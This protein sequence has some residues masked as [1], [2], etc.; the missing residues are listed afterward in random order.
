MLHSH[1]SAITLARNSTTPQDEEEQL[2]VGNSEGARTVVSSDDF[3]QSQK[4]SK[5]NITKEEMSKYFN[6]PQVLAARLL[7]VSVSTLKRRYYEMFKGRWPYQSLS[8]TERKKSI[9]FYVNEE[10]HPEK[11]IPNE[12]LM[13]LQKAFSDCTKPSN[14]Y[15]ISTLQGQDP[16]KKEIQFLSYVPQQADGSN[17][18]GMSKE[19]SQSEKGMFVGGSRQRYKKQTGSPRK[20]RKKQ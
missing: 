7:N 11:L 20:L 9:W 3:N 1:N 19:D 10:D 6:A 14:E 8:N 13:V 17:S 2:T 4:S 16:K 12:T 15:L 18:T 5:I